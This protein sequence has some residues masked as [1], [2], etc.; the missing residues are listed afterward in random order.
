MILPAQVVIIRWKADLASL[1]RINSEIYYVNI[2]RV[3][4][5]PETSVALS[6]NASTINE[7][8]VTFL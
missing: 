1:L 4:I 6:R 2:L 7:T 8:S 3:D 5:A